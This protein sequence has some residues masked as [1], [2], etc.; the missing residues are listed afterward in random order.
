MSLPTIHTIHADKESQLVYL[1]ALIE[2]S[3]V[4]FDYNVSNPQLEL[5]LLNT[6]N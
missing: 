1:F 4:T 5:S 2:K 6:A 3:N